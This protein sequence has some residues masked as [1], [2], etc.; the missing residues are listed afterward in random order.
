[1]NKPDDHLRQVLEQQIKRRRRAR[2]AGFLGLLLTGGTLGLLFTVPIVIGAYLGRWLDL[3][4]TGY[5]VRWTISLI[6]LGIALG[7]YNLYCF[8]K[9]LWNK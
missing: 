9:G 8:I 6:L 4:V 2:P 1:M 7:A 5:S 3:H